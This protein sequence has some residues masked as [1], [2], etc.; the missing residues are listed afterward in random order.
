MAVNRVEHTSRGKQWMCLNTGQDFKGAL[1]VHEEVIGPEISW[2]LTEAIPTTQRKL[3]EGHA[4]DMLFPCT[5]KL[6]CS[7]S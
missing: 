7:C 5:R 6:N 3:A 1:E 2:E 4:T